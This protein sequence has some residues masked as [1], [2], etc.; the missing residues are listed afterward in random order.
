MLFLTTKNYAWPSSKPTNLAN[1]GIYVRSGW[2]EELC[3]W[4]YYCWLCIYIYMYPHYIIII[5]LV[6]STVW[7][8]WKS[9]GM[10]IPNI[11]DNKNHVPNHQAVI[12]SIYPFSGFKSNIE[13]CQESAF[14][15]EHCPK[16]G[17][18]KRFYWLIE[19]EIPIKLSSTPLVI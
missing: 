8:I 17:F 18:W 3:I 13:Q 1:V 4:I 7:K 14:Q 5:F 15:S 16:P 12:I 19:I 10:I 2:R 11:S 9:V 6:I